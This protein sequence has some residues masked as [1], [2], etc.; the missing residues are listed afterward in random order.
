MYC[1]NCG[2]KIDLNDKF[3]ISCG[4]EIEK[5]DVVISNN[6]EKV[7]KSGNDVSSLV[8]GIFSLVLFFVPVIGLILGIISMILGASY[9]RK[10]NNKTVGFALG[11]SGT[12]LNVVFVAF[13][14][15]IFIFSFFD[16]EDYDYDYYDRYNSVDNNYM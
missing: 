2:N 1:K 8:L 11:M 5:N 3:C 15:M 14:I 13:L 16:E 6:L 10:S 7:D 4:T 12:I 9:N